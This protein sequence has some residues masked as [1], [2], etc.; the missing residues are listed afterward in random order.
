MNL[1]HEIFVEFDCKLRRRSLVERWPPAFADVVVEREL[2]NGEYY[3]VRVGERQV[4]LAAFVV[5]A[6]QSDNFP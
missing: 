1:A 3:S 4:H 2:R 5:E 6:A